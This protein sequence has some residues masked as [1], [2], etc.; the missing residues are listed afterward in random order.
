MVVRDKRAGYMGAFRMLLE[1]APYDL[2][3]SLHTT[4]GEQKAEKTGNAYC[5]T[6]PSLLHIF[7]C[8]LRDSVSYIPGR[9]WICCVAEDLLK[10]LSFC[11]YLQNARITGT[12]H[13]AGFMQSWDWVQDLRHA[14][15][16]LY[17]LS[18]ITRSV[19]LILT[20]TGHYVESF[21]KDVPGH[22][23]ERPSRLC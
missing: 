16:A 23:C 9:S 5:K 22:A 11:L 2:Q 19:W 18:H 20:S 7:V 15:Q 14:R 21:R 3:F 12:C 8:L 10:C 1:S 13:Q 4:A 6:G 17:Q